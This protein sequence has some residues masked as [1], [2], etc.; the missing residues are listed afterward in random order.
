MQQEQILKALVDQGINSLKDL[1]FTRISFGSIGM[2]PTESG[3]RALSNGIDFTMFMHMCVKPAVTEEEY[4]LICD[5]HDVAMRH[6][7]QKLDKT[8]VEQVLQIFTK[9][10]RTGR[11]L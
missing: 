2:T 4:K 3:M 5:L 10:A 11:V 6:G 7:R 1:T 9:W 8:K